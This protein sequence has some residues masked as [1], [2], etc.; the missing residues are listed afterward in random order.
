M[1]MLTEFAPIVLFFVAYKLY[2]IYV[3]TAVIIVATAIAVGIGW[4]RHRKI[5]KMQVVT[6]VLVLVLGGA[7]LILQ[8]ERF[9]KWKP[10]VVDWVIAGAFLGSHYIGDKPLLQRAL[11][12]QIELPREL[13]LKMSLGWVVFFSV[14]GVVNLAVAYTMSTNAWVN[15]KLFGTLGLTAAFVLAQAYWL[16]KVAPEDADGAD[17]ADGADDTEASSGEG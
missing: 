5:E 12:E 9:V 14:L 11:G 2:D 16:S 6:L 17:G 7:T 8:D 3:A 1:K 10:T 4:L 15:F 13:W